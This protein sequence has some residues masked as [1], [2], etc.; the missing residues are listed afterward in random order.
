MLIGSA[1]ESFCCTVIHHTADCGGIVSLQALVLRE[2][3][4]LTHTHTH[5]KN[6]VIFYKTDILVQLIP[7]K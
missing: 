1:V 3:C 7:N 2:A 5:R 6:T 4:C